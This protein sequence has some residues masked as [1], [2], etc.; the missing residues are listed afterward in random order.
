MSEGKEKD[1]LRLAAL[2][3]LIADEDW[4]RIV[5]ESSKKGQSPLKIILAQGLLDEEQLAALK[6]EVEAS[7]RQ[8]IGS[9]LAPESKPGRTRFIEGLDGNATDSLHLDPHF[10]ANI[11]ELSPD[12]GFPPDWDRYQFVSFLGEG[13][14]GR[15]FLAHDP[16]LDRDV[17]IK[18]VRCVDK[19]SDLRFKNE[20]QAQARVKHDF[21]CDI[22][23]VGDVDGRNYIVMQYI[24]GT[25]LNV[26]AKDMVL[27]QKLKVVKE[28]A[29]AVHQAHR[30]GLIHRDLKPSNIMVERLQDGG[31]KP[32]VMDFGLAKQ[33]AGPGL[34]ATGSVIGT[35]H[36]MPPE[37][38]RGESHKMDR[39]ADVYS[40]GATLYEILAGKPPF[41]GLSSVNVLFKVLN[42]D[43]TSIRSDH[44]NIPEDVETITFKCLEKEVAKRYESARALAEDL[45]R[46][47]DG[48]PIKA[49]PSSFLYRLKKKIVKNKLAVTIGA[50]ALVAVMTAVGWGIYGR[51]AAKERAKLAR[52]FGQSAENIE[53][54]VRYLYL[55][56]RHDISPQQEK[57][58]AEMA[59]I[60]KRV[61]QAG[62]FGI[63]PGNYALGRGYL[64]LGAFD[65]A[66]VHLKMAWD[67]NFREPRAA[68]A[69]GLTLGSLY[70]RELQ[71]VDQISSKGRRLEEK[72]KII[73]KFR[74]PAASYLQMARK[75]E[76]E[77]PDYVE[78]LLA[79][80]DERFDEAIK[81]TAQAYE[82]LPWLYEAH[83]LEGDILAEMGNQ[84]RDK[85]EYQ[86]ALIPYGKA[87]QSYDKAAE[88]GESDS[89][90]YLGRGSLGLSMMLMEIYGSGKDV[91]PYFEV[92][93]QAC[94]YALESNPGLAEAMMLK[95]EI[96]TRLGEYQHSQGQNPVENFR[97]AIL[98][99][100]IA[101]ARS[102]DNP[103]ANKKLAS[104]HRELARY[105]KSIG[106]DPR[107]NL[108]LALK[109]NQ[110]SADSFPSYSNYNG[111]GLILKAL[112]E[113][114]HDHGRDPRA[115]WRDATQAF[116]KALGIESKAG[117]RI[118]L[119]SICIGQARFETEH[120][121]DPI[122]Y[123]NKGIEYCHQVLADNPNHP[124]MLNNFGRALLAVSERALA[125]GNDPQKPLA[126]AEKI[127]RRGIEVNPKR[128][129]YYYGLG[130]IHLFQGRYLA[131]RGQ[132]PGQALR[133]AFSAADRIF[134]IN[135]QHKDARDLKANCHLVAAEYEM[136]SGG[137]PTEQLQQS[138]AGFREILTSQPNDRYALLELGDALLLQ[139]NYHLRSGSLKIDDLN[140]LRAVVSQLMDYHG[141][142]YMSHYLEAKTHALIAQLQKT[143]GVEPKESFTRAEKAFNTALKTN[144]GDSK[145]LSS[146]AHLLWNYALYIKEQGLPFMALV[147]RGLNRAEQSIAI[148]PNNAYSHAL[149]ASLKQMKNPS[150][151]QNSDLGE[152]SRQSANK[153]LEINPLVVFY[154]PHIR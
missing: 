138:I 95:S 43:P 63:G 9:G 122:P 52:E 34:T 10:S 15:V 58:R 74:A 27:E 132:N 117:A 91:R 55:I 67:A 135:A 70:Q 59:A 21:L 83:K 37:Q 116:E 16:R 120:G 62:S 112:G 96:F 144:S 13:G 154:Y 54:R 137:N 73:K 2:K 24:D 104:A 31:F 7:E 25:A 84:L 130:K 109:A 79:F 140:P 60:Q 76:L 88:V 30:T 93:I 115:H 99:A 40:L 32:H 97:K 17:A 113:Y 114:E 6:L 126:E 87:A 148:N 41:M 142:I 92:G 105:F 110:A 98:N 1:V 23:E 128:S 22:Y 146:Y 11:S 77:S 3:G 82:R 14:M 26:A 44:P 118:N 51:W 85:G 139:N 49:R 100:N 153:A 35:P 152:A 5:A 68:Y 75:D 143:Q 12:H 66:L 133:K 129:G 119:V 33:Q 145:I 61:E 151:S 134:D 42:D 69:L 36:Y 78:A 48:E 80:Y 8:T 65:E 45:G 71:T 56:P 103:H 121:R 150:T 94:N 107:P 147:E 123:L 18:F 47:L 81:K 125:L 141:N 86:Q 28:V 111:L 19:E 102:P 108:K 106:L 57:L 4:A 136:I 64:A 127:I 39:R 90:V 72:E 131:S 38:A 50:V 53:D 149:I 101:L 89:R 29:E 46:Y 20:A 124:S